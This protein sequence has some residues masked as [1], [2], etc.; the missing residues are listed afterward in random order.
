MFYTYL[1]LRD[2]GTPYYVGKGRGKRAYNNYH[3]L[4]PPINRDLIRI[5]LWEDE[6]VAFAYER[7]FIDF[8]GRK[9]LGTGCLRNLTDGGQGTSGAKHSLESRSRRKGMQNALGYRHT[10]QELRTM[11]ESQ[12]GKP[13]RPKTEEEKRRISEG[14][15]LAML[16]PE[17]IKKMRTPRPS[18]IGN[19]NA[20]GK[21]FKGA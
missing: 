11:S 8:Y 2:D 3:R 10:E 21:K 9:D 18:L 4:K 6:A 14:T 7:Y 20:L 13:R 16:N 12:K 1:W 5:Q 19:K 15:K 17:V